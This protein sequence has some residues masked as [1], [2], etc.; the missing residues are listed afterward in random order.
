MN[1]LSG[2]VLV[3]SALA[4][5]AGGALSQSNRDQ[6]AGASKEWPT[7]GHD[8]GGRRYSPLT[9]ITPENVVRL[10]VA[11]VYHMKPAG[12]AAPSP[13]GGDAAAA[14]GRGASGK[15]NVTV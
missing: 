2:A 1:R 9:E 3:G 14:V 6:A 4:I 5:L 8:P 13:R 7:Y 15:A 11:W 10:K 12:E